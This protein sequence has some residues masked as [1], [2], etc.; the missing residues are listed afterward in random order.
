MPL[1]LQRHV[2][3]VA[4]IGRD[5][6]PA[7]YDTP[8]PPRGGKEVAG[9]FALEPE[10]V[11]IDGAVV[12]GNTTS[13]CTVAVTEARDDFSGSHVVEHAQKRDIGASRVAKILDKEAVGRN[14]I[15]PH[16]GP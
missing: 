1:E 4:G 3:S 9:V 14:I 10:R 2:V 16:T 12:V 11:V 7:L 8:P 13:T 15:N 6:L 5:E